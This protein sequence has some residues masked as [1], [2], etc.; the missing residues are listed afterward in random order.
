MNDS[1]SNVSNNVKRYN[2]EDKPKCQNPNAKS[3]SKPK[4]QNSNDKV[5]VV[6]ILDFDIRI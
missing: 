6:F 1:N 2:L 4:C 5:D 3:M